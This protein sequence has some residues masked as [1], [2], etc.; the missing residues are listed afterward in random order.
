MRL[1]PFLLLCACATPAA[2]LYFDAREISPRGAFPSPLVDG[3]VN[4]RRTRFVV[5][6]GAQVSVID[7]ALAADA[8]LVIGEGVRGQDPSGQAVKMQQTLEPHLAVDGLGELP[9]RP[10]A[11]ATLP[12]FFAQLGIGA[13]VSPQSLAD[14]EHSV[15]LD[16]PHLKLQRVSAAQPQGVDVCGYK[17]GSLEAKALVATATIDGTPTLVELDTGASRTFLV[18]DSEVGKRLSSRPDVTRSQ[19]VGAAGPIEVVGL[20][21]VTIG[22]GGGD[23]PG[24]LMVMPGTKDEQ[25]RYEGRLGIDRL[26]ACT[27]VIS[28]GSASA[29]CQ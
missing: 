2:S 28:T 9:D 1:S 5:D 6:T 25:C 18:A 13:I 12:P 21:S 26:K 17:E 19:A 23:T 22:L 7:A 11:V 20:S 24:P 10:S 27:I 14:A 16:L 8:G 4:G 15:V 29:T 3:T